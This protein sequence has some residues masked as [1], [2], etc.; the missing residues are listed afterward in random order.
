M[1]QGP[2]KVAVILRRLMPEGVGAVTLTQ[3]SEPM[4]REPTLHF[5][6]NLEGLMMKSLEELLK[7][8]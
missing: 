7:C 8:G 4:L 5:R 3:A 6:P 2:N 1:L